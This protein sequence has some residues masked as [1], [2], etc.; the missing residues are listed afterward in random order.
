[1][2][3]GLY[4]AWGAHMVNMHVTPK[5][6]ANHQRTSRTTCA[7]VG[8]SPSPCRTRAYPG[9]FQALPAVNYQEADT[10]LLWHDQNPVFHDVN[11]TARVPV[12]KCSLSVGGLPVV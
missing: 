9:L 12:H 2:V 5:K 4:A 1:M 8:R 6:A 10:Q 3:E 7:S 11:A